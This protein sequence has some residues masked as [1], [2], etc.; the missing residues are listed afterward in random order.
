[1]ERKNFRPQLQQYFSAIQ[2]ERRGGGGR[3]A[4]D[5]E[6]LVGGV[7]LGFPNHDPIPDQS[8]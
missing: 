7:W 8:M 6:F 1:M 3:G 2:G 4:V 5:S